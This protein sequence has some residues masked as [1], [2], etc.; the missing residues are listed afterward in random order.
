MTE[1]T[2]TFT[3]EALQRMPTKIS[4]IRDGSG[5]VFE[6]KVIQAWG[7][8]IV[9]AAD[10]PDRLDAMASELCSRD[11]TITYEEAVNEILALG[12]TITEEAEW[13]ASEESDPAGMEMHQRITSVAESTGRSYEETFNELSADGTLDAI[14][15][16]HYPAS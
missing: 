10:H 5:H 15:S 9:T 4:E 11:R 6:D 16:R 3:A 14:Y 1:K 2:E 7:R 8:T 13:A 12:Q